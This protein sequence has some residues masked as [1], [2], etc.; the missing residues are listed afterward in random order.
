MSQPA[1]TEFLKDEV[2][3][4]PEFCELRACDGIDASYQHMKYVFMGYRNDVLGNQAEQ[5]YEPGSMQDL[6]FRDGVLLAKRDLLHETKRAQSTR[7]SS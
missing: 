3:P 5:T 2:N 1:A 4:D 7:R 6:S